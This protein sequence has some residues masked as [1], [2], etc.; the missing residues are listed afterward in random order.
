MSIIF[1]AL[2]TPVLAMASQT[3]DQHINI[4]SQEEIFSVM[5]TRWASYFLG[6]PNLP[7]NAKLSAEIAVIN[8]EALELLKN[9]QLNKEGL[10]TRATA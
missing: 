6:D 10:W 8:N 3:T 1:G 9:L 2:S 5:R 7:M 4:T